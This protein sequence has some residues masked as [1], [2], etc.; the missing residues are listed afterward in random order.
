M[1]SY[2]FIYKSV[3]VRAYYS[4]GIHVFI[5]VYGGI[6]G[7]ISLQLFIENGGNIFKRIEEEIWEKRKSKKSGIN[8]VSFC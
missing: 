7:G 6:R 4:Y 2:V 1:N 3:D 8:A 5:R